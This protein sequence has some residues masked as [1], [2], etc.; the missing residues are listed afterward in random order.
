MDLN[1]NALNEE[2]L[3]PE[4]Y[5]SLSKEEKANI[6]S[7]NIIPATFESDKDFGKIHVI[8]KAPVYKVEL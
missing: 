7:S 5:L 1:T 3:S 4:E 2:N 6:C 8:Y